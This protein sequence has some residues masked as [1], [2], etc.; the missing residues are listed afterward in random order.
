MSGANRKVA[1][2]KHFGSEGI[3]CYVVGKMFDNRFVTEFTHNGNGSVGDGDGVDIAL[4]GSSG[5]FL[6]QVK[7][8]DTCAEKFYLAQKRLRMRRE[9]G[10]GGN[11]DLPIHILVIRPGTTI[12]DVSRGLFCL[13]SPKRKRGGCQKCEEERC[14]VFRPFLYLNWKRRRR[15]SKEKIITRTLLPRGRRGGLPY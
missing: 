10:N 15:S 3:V 6:L 13:T 14:I 2:L 5:T 12:E 1:H 8:S 9:N 11:G 4:E 7:S